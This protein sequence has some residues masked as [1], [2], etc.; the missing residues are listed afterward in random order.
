[1]LPAP[2]VRAGQILRESGITVAGDISDGLVR[3]VVRLAEASQLGAII[4]DAWLPVDPDARERFGERA[5]L[6]LAGRGYVLETGR[7]VAEGPAAAL[8]AD[9]RLQASYLGTG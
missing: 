3:E 7:I 5:A 9:P 2:R 1:M 6:R 4:D 8:L